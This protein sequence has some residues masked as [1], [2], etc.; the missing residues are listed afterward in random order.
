MIPPAVLAC[1]VYGACG[2]LAASAVEYLLRALA[3]DAGVN[4]WVF[5][6]VPALFAMLFALLLYQDAQRRIRKIGESVSRGILIAL[7]SWFAFSMLASWVW[8]PLDAF[9]QC[10]SRALLAS[11]IVGGGPMLAAAIVGGLLT[12]MLI[13]RPPRKR[14]PTDESGGTT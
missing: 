5:V 11:A 12:G 1:L 7:L 2:L 9:G 10:L 8:C 13:V 6:A 3:D 4:R 14:A